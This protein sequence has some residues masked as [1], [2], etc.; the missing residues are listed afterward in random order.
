M[1]IVITKSLGTVSHGITDT[2]DRCPGMIEGSPE[3]KI[4]INPVPF[5]IRPT[6]FCTRGIRRIRE[7]LRIISTGGRG[8][9][10]IILCS[11]HGPS[12]QL[13]DVLLVFLMF[14]LLGQ[15]RIK[16]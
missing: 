16:N 12:T 9:N 8:K 1:N 7:I 14:I 5:G 15:Q 11:R 13:P 6:N 3:I 2:L 10:R 4:E